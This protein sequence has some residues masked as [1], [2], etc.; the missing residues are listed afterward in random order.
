[1]STGITGS[2]GSTGSTGNAGITGSTGDAAG[3]E[4]SGLSA[5]RDLRK[6]RRRHRLADI[7]WSDAIYRVYVFTL[8][9][10]GL[11]WWVIATLGSRP[12]D[13]E[14]LRSFVR[15][16]PVA[17]GGLLASAVWGGVRSGVRGGPVALEHAELVH[18]L[19]SPLDRKRILRYPSFQQY[20][21]GLLIGSGVGAVAGRMTSPFVPGGGFRWTGVGLVFGAVCG[22]L[23]MGSALVTSGRRLPSLRTQLVIGVL[24]VLTVLNLWVRSLPAPFS[25]L[26][27]SVLLGLSSRVHSTS[28]PL[29]AAAVV[30][31]IALGVAAFGIAGC[32][33]INI[34]RAQQRA[35]LVGQL[36]FAVTT[37]DL[38]AVVLVRRQ[39]NADVNRRDPWITVPSGKGVE[40]AVLARSAKSFARWPARR[41]VRLLLLASVAGITARAGW[42][43]AVPLFLIPGLAAFLAGLDVVEPLSQ[44]ADHLSL[45]ASYPRHRGRL[46]NRLII[47]PGLVLVVVG[48]VG[49]LIGWVSALLFG[50]TLEAKQ[51]GVALALGVVWALSGTLAAALSVALGPPPFM[52]MIQTPEIGFARMASL[53]VYA[54][55]CIGAP[56]L[57]AQRAVNAGNSATPSFVKVI[58]AALAL[59]YLLLNVLTSAGIREPK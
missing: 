37:Q 10:G 14:G 59:T 54:V 52:M 30:L 13:A 53:P 36:R 25:L 51:I 20:R 29:V 26:G 23:W 21:R 47:V 7:H 33:G 31:V 39:L 5:L 27:R 12:V 55:A 46:A 49:A 35:A 42:G 2:T 1:M 50:Q 45:L 58:G 43:G 16:A 44:D 32:H 57:F 34:E 8:A 38:R 3:Q 28:V 15:F 41:F 56:L 11:V 6:A 4:A 48:I 18:V 24:M 22:I 40:R 17:A 19:G 9:V